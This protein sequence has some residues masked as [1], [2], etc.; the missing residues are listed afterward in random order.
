[1]PR[2]EKNNYDILGV[3]KNASADEIKRAYRKLAREHH[4]DVNK[5][6]GSVDKFKEINA[7]YQ[8][9]SDPEKRSK[10]DYFGTAEAQGGGFSGFDFGTSFESFGE[11]GDLFDAVFGRGRGGRRA[12]EERGAD[13]RYDLHIKLEDVFSGIEKEI[14]IYHHTACPTCKGSGAKPGTSPTRCSA[15]KGSGQIS[16][17]QRTILGSFVQVVPCPTCQG[18]GEVI[19]SPCSTCHGQGRIKKSHK[20]TVKVPSGIEPGYRLRVAGAGDAG[21]KGSPSG[22]LYIY[23]H[24]EP[25]PHFN[26]DGEDLYYRT[27]INFIQAILGDEI[28]IPTLAGEA[29]LK[30]PPGT[31]P[32]TTFK[33]KGKGLPILNKRETGNLFVL[34]EVEIPQKLSR[35]QEDLL[36]KMKAL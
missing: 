9:L 8:V 17:S 6:A 12:R 22:D 36:K 35:E 21:E 13:L 7:A 26:R 11:F 16:K 2:S 25:H 33:I 27:K 3:G 20:V 24:V 23:I 1:M 19:S 31:Q 28:N 29:T 34:V 15:C 32:N 10:Y 18:S 30:V 4:P 5:S 14:D